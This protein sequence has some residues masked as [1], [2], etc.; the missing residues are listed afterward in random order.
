VELGLSSERR[1][2]AGGVESGICSTQQQQLRESR[3]E[4]S[5]AGTA[6]HWPVKIGTNN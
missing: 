6:E 4:N 1:R 3:K 2:L 5:A